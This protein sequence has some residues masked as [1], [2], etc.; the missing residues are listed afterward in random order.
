MKVIEPMTPD[1]LHAIL[2]REGRS[3]FQYLRE[4]P[5]WVGPNDRNS[6][7]RVRELAGAESE[8]IESLSKLMQKHHG[9]YG[10][11][12]AFPDFTHYNDA[13]LHFLLPMVIREQKQ[14]LNELETDRKTVTDADAGALLDQLLALKRQH[15][16]QLDDMR[17]GA[18]SFTTVNV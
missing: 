16:P 1:R 18:H 12:G 11:L 7:A 9:D 17:P 4:A 2:R 15:I 3:L 8:V 6:L 14:L 5:P 13:A 10:H